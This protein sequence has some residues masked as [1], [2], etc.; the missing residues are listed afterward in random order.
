MQPHCSLPLR[1]LKPTPRHIPMPSRRFSAWTDAQLIHQQALQQ[2]A[3]ER[4]ETFQNRAQ[5][6]T[7]SIAALGLVCAAVVGV[8]GNPVVAS[9]IALASIGGPTTAIA[10]A[11]LVPAGRTP[12]RGPDED[13][14]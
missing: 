11:R 12:G 5:L 2:Q 1:H 4:W 6:L 9:V 13:G 10:L 3:V 14:R 8:F 7:A